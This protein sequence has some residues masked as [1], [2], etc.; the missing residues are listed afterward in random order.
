MRGVVARLCDLGLSHDTTPSP[1]TGFRPIEERRSTLAGCG[2]ADAGCPGAPNNRVNESLKRCWQIR[3]SRNGVILVPY[4]VWLPG[5]LGIGLD[6]P[7]KISLGG[8]R[9]LQKIKKKTRK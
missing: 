8:L 3:C 6:V 1:V 5:E 2:G 9:T 4:G 7:P